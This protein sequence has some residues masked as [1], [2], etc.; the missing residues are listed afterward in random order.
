MH[1]YPAEQRCLRGP[2]TFFSFCQNQGNDSACRRLCWCCCRHHHH[3]PHGTASPGQTLAINT[4]HLALRSINEKAV[5]ITAAILCGYWFLLGLPDPKVGSNNWSFFIKTDNTE[6][7]LEPRCFL[8]TV[9]PV[10]VLPGEKIKTPLLVGFS[11]LC[12]W[13]AAGGIPTHTAIKA[14]RSCIPGQTHRYGLTGASRWGRVA[15]KRRTIILISQMGRDWQGRGLLSSRTQARPQSFF[16]CTQILAPAFPP[17][18][19]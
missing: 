12:W 1:L 13:R 9:P 17:H 11:C 4:K 10:Q 5:T 6:R 18:I 8:W 14:A 16:L 15:G 19:E 2:H 3:F 7:Q